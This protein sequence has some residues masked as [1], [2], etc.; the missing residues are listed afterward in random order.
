MNYAPKQKR[1]ETILVDANSGKVVRNI[2]II[3]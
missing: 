1:S 2:S 3:G